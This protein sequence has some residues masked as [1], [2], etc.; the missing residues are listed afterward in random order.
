MKEQMDHSAAPIVWLTKVP[1]PEIVA[2]VREDIARSLDGLSRPEKLIFHVVS[3]TKDA[4][5]PTV[6]LSG[7]EE[8]G[9]EASYE[10]EYEPIEF[11]F[12]TLSPEAQATI[13]EAIEGDD[14][15]S[16]TDGNLKKE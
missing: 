10:P 4:H 12:S 11:P 6:V 7:R 16:P 5:G 13:R 14:E 1:P 15:P 2:I 9:F 8:G 3:L